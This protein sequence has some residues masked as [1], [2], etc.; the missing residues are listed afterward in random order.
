MPDPSSASDIS[1]IQITDTH[2]FADPKQ[3]MYGVPTARSLSDV[4]RLVRKE[5]EA[6]DLVLATGDL[7]QDES[8]GSYRVLEEELA[9]LERPVYCIPGNHDVVPTLRKAVRTDWI[10]PV[11]RV[12]KGNWQILL[13]NS[14]VAGKVGGRLAEDELRRVDEQI[15]EEPDLH[16]LIAL[17]HHPVPIGAPWMDSIMLE[18]GEAL[19]SKLA[20]YRQVKAVVFGHIHQEFR[21]DVAGL[22]FFG[23]P[24][25]S[26]QFKPRVPAFELDT[27]PPG[28]RWFRLR[29]D[30]TLET[31]V[32]R[33]PPGSYTPDKTKKGY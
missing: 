24:S 30:G 28:Y 21:S 2:L 4:V 22:P 12:L 5:E 29:P 1:L 14:V 31:G 20:G 18:N 17:H 27:V 9:R 23:A 8:E 7:S 6:L 19:V 32:R 16:C 13:L 15:R 10:A 26:V 33:L 25:T 11:G 3:E